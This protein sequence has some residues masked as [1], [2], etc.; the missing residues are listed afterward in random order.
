MKGWD[1]SGGYVNKFYEFL[2]MIENKVIDY[3][4]TLSESIFSSKLSREELVGLF[5][6]NIKFSPNHDPKF[7]V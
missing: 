2:Q 5:N 7:R 1:Q 4:E 3:V 6:S